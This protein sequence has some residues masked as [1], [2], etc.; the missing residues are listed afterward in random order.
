MRPACWR[1]VP[2]S[3]PNSWHDRFTSAS[4]PALVA[5][6]GELLRIEHL[7]ERVHR[8][9]VT[10]KEPSRPAQ[11]VPSGLHPPDA[12]LSCAAVETAPAPVRLVPLGGLGEVGMNC[13]LVETPASRLVVDCGVLFPG[14]AAGLG[15]EI[16]P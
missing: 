7:G 10:P 13:L 15:V 9:R 2:T 11:S 6:G 4:W 14:C 3:T 5:D 1:A 8:L 12:V 16:S